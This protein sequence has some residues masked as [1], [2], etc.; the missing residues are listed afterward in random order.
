MFAIAI[1]LAVDA[2][3]GSWRWGWIVEL[4]LATVLLAQRSLFDH[5][6][7]VA[8]ALKNEG[9]TGGRRAVALIVGRD[10]ETLDASAVARAA[11]ESC[12]ESFCDGVVGPVFWYMLAGLPGLLAVKTVN[13]MDS[14]IGHRNAHYRDFG[15][16]AARLDD[17]MML[18]PARLAGLLLCLAAAFVPKGRP[19]RAL[20]VMWRD[21]GKHASPNAGWPEAAMAGAF[22]LR[23]GG[24]RRYGGEV[25]AAPWIGNGRV[26]ATPADIHAALMLL[27]VACLIEAGLA[28]LFVRGLG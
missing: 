16:V 11:I 23:L 14:M 4:L 15:M 19:D 25:H 7:R 28:V 8:I 26:V 22:D 3:R 20:A 9:L 18:L 12:A 27:A 13:T 24:P 5:V 21:H 10:P 1:G 6:R 17:V 2:L